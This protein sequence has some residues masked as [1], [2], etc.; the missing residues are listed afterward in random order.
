MGNKDLNFNTIEEVCKRFN[1]V[2]PKTGFS[3][4]GAAPH[5]MNKHVVFWWASRIS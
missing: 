2:A 1:I 4:R 3:Y 5:P